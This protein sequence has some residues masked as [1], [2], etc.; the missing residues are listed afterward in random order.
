MT[1]GFNEGSVS[2]LTEHVHSGDGGNR[3]A[4]FNEGSV[5]LLTEQGNSNNISS[6]E[7]TLQ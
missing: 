5:S 2:L 1:Q 3:I 4:C 7:R 6:H